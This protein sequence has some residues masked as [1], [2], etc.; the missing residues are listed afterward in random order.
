MLRWPQAGHRHHYW[1][2]KGRGQPDF[3]AGGG[4]YLWWRPIRE[5]I[6]HLSPITSVG[7]ICWRASSIVSHSPPGTSASVSRPVS[8]PPSPPARTHTRTHSIH[9]SILCTKPGMSDGRQ[10]IACQHIFQKKKK[11]K[12]Q[13]SHGSVFVL[14][15]NVGV[16]IP[17][18][19]MPCAR[20]S[21]R[22]HLQKIGRSR[23]ME[24]E[25]N[26]RGRVCKGRKKKAG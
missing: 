23:Q 11:K 5:Q 26:W 3:R 18:Q 14:S 2:D 13:G 7:C 16:Q 22:L 21:R 9:P 25:G 1:T 15:L 8:Q 20:A 19:K 6:S 24:R 4:V 17:S 12:S 10:D